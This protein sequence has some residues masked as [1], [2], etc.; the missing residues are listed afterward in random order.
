L[1]VRLCPRLERFQDGCYHR[2]REN[3]RDNGE[4]NQHRYVVDIRDEHLCSYECQDSRQ[5]VVQEPEYLYRPGEREI[6]CSEPE[7]GKH[8]RSIDYEGVAR[9]WR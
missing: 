2:Q 6:K 9:D 4:R 5:P 1:V 8:V 3:P 7:D